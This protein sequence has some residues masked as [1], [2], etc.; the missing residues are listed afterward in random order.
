MRIYYETLHAESVSG[1]TYDRLRSYIPDVNR[2]LLHLPREIS[3]VLSTWAEALGPVVRQ[4]EHTHRGRFAGWGSPDGII[5]DLWVMFGEGGPC[6]GIV[7]DANG[8]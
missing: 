5:Q 8:Y 7:P 1:I 2:G 4:S 3:V 6:Y